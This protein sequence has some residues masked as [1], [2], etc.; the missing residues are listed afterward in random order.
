MQ[1]YKDLRHGT[2]S[3]WGIAFK[4]YLRISNY[5]VQQ[6]WKIELLCNSS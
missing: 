5:N 4:F 6:S 2:Q 1:Q 3:E